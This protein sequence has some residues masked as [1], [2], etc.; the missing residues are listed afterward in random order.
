MLPRRFLVKSIL[1]GVKNN[2][3][4][5]A[6]GSAGFEIL[7]SRIADSVMAAAEIFES[8]DEPSVISDS[9][10][11]EFLRDRSLHSGQAPDS[12]E[13]LGRDLPVAE[14]P[15]LQLPQ[16]PQ[17]G[18]PIISPDSAE[19]KEVMTRQRGITPIRPA[20]SGSK[21]EGTHERPNWD[22]NNL[23]GTIMGVMPVSIKVTPEGQSGSVELERSFQADASLGIIKVVYSPALQQKGS[24][25]STPLSS[26]DSPMSIPVDISKS[27][28]VYDPLGID[29]DREIFDL[30]SLARKSFRPR[31]Q[32]VPSRTPVIQG[33]TLEDVFREANT[34]S[35]E[36]PRRS[37]FSG[38]FD[39]V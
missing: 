9:Q 21:P 13:D 4:I 12:P 14:R 29:F 28:N 24:S 15:L 22:Y 39:S 18:S 26:G 6:R 37:A 11:Q 36:S 38:S 7:A 17:D 1:L 23:Y 5:I 27:F 32:N 31:Q 3:D 25:P 8:D 30:Q 34:G 33:R 19:A 20:R 16:P 2:Q 10:K 35:P